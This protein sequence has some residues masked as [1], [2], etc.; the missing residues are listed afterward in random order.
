M[1]ASTK[2]G[3]EEKN[4]SS[5][6]ALQLPPSVSSSDLRKEDN[7]NSSPFN[8]KSL[9][10]EEDDDDDE[11]V[12]N[13][14]PILLNLSLTNADA[15]GKS[16]FILS[17]DGDNEFRSNSSFLVPSDKAPSEVGSI[18][19]AKSAHDSETHVEVK[20]SNFCAEMI[21]LPIGVCQ[22]S[23]EF[24]EQMD[25]FMRCQHP[26]DILAMFHEDEVERA[27]VE[28]FNHSYSGDGGGEVHR[29]SGYHAIPRKC[30]YCGAHDV[31]LCKD[32]PKCER[33]KTFFPREKPPF[34]SKGGSK[35]KEEKNAGTSSYGEQR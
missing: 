9:F 15:A 14:N 5:N 31:D 12:G 25:I 7:N 21:M 18:S 17:D 11:D 16:S 26:L 35:W 28:N 23:T 34:Y 29:V 32:D 3:E 13:I 19:E 27:S 10:E 6:A 33:P 1:C 30:E 22:G 20:N 4:D 24:A 8:D 2:A